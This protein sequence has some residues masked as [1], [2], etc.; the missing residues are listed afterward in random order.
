MRDYKINTLKIKR[1]WNTFKNLIFLNDIKND[2]NNVN[3]LKIYFFEFLLFFS[4]FWFF[5]NIYQKY[6]LKIK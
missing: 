3:I 2:K 1:V 5:L 6:C 4:Y